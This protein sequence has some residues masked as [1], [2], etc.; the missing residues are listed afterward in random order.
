MKKKIIFLGLILLILIGIN[1]TE[2]STNWQILS[3]LIMNFR[4][5]RLI[6][7]L[8]A[9]LALAISGLLI[10][11]VAENPL[12]DGGTIG[13]TSGA[14]AGTVLFLLVAQNLKLTGWW[15]YSYPV[16]AV[17]GAL[18]AFAMIYYFALR[19][20]VS[21]VRVLLTGIAITAFFQSV[22][23]IA[24][25][26]VNAFDFQQVAVWLSGDVWQTSGNY[27]VVCLILLLIALAFLPFFLKKIEVLALGEE[28]ATTLGLDVK[29]TKLQLYVL[30]LFF[31]V[32]A[33]LLVGGLAFVGLIAPHI[34][35]E[36]GGFSVKKRLPL[37]VLSGMIILV[38]ADSLSQMLI[39]PSSLPLGLVVAFIGA[40]YYIYL[41]QKI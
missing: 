4:L 25:L 39:A 21:N 22:I 6:I 18:L 12:A 40:P 34:A 11:T 30:A 27:I 29:K 23:T 32:V 31:A 3:L 13:I 2:F 14:S 35:R 37:T 19:K 5:P 36:L 10:Q 16:F 7:V 28:V 8:S 9:G 33:V 1:L 26:S 41:I 17:L 24:Q 38:L 15:N 20:N